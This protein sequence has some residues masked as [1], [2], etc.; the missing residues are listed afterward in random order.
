M[1]VRCLISCSSLLRASSL[2]AKR[3]CIFVNPPKQGFI[4]QNIALNGP[5]QW[6]GKYLIFFKKNPCSLLWLFILS[7][8]PNFLFTRDKFMLTSIRRQLFPS[9]CSLLQL[10]VLVVTFPPLFSLF[11]YH[12]FYCI[13]ILFININKQNRIVTTQTSTDN[14]KRHE[15]LRF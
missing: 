10:S 9:T 11:L 15:V 4:T 5:I 1:S 14:N 12:C 13:F 3:I 6:S 7:H 2:A 8:F